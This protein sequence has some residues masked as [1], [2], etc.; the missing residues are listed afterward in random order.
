MKIN[1]NSSKIPDMRTVSVYNYVC[2]IHVSSIY[3]SPVTLN[4]IE[5]SKKNYKIA[6]IRLQIVLSLGTQ[7]I[8]FRFTFNL[9][10]I[11]FKI[12]NRI[13]LPGAT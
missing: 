8:V 12:F 13:Y 9:M 2:K 5:L 4:T 10:I 1:D 3:D 11:K 6:L 7:S